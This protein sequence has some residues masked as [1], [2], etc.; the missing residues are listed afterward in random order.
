MTQEA[1]N[2][3]PLNS[4]AIISNIELIFKNKDINKLNKPTYNF[5][6]NLGGF[7]AH[8]DLNGF[9]YHYED[10]RQF[11]EDLLNS[12]SKNDANYQLDDD[13]IK[14]YGKAYCQSEADAING[15]REVVLKYQNDVSST[16]KSQDEDK[17][18]NI[19]KLAEEVKRR[20]DPELTRNFLAKI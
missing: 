5:V 10:L 18:D 11:A 14:W 3:K 12:C 20:N 8:Y 6:M 13:F 17:L 19:I 2:W 16:C 7:I 1:G 9:Q 4:K 15:I